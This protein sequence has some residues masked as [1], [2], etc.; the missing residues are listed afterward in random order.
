[1]LGRATLMALIAIMVIARIDSRTTS[2][3]PR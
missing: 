2:I 3:R 1:M